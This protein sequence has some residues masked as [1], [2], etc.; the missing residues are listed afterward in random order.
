MHTTPR[1]LRRFARSMNFRNDFNVS[2]TKRGTILGSDL[3]FLLLNDNDAAPPLWNVANQG[4]SSVLSRTF[5]Q[6]FG[7]SARKEPP[8]SRGLPLLGS[9]LSLTI[10]GGAKKLHEYVDNKHQELGP[11]FRDQIGPIEAVFVNSPAEYRKVLADLAGNTPRHFLPESWMLYNE[12]R[13]QNRGLLFMEGEE[14]WHYRKILNKVML[15]PGPKIFFYGPCQE[16]AENLTKEW[17]RYC[18]IGCVIPNLEH[19]LYQWSIEVMLAAMIGSRWHVCEPRLRCDIEDLATILH[20]IF[21]YTS[22]LSMIPAKLAMKLRLPVWNKFVQAA[23][24]VL[25]KV[26]KLVPEMVRLSDNDGLLQTIL[27]NGIRGDEAVRIICDFVIAAGDTTSITMQW[28]LLLLSSHPELQDRLFNEI[29]DLPLEDLLQHQLLRYTWKETLR[30]HPVAPFLTRYLPVDSII[31][32]YFVPKGDLIIL[33][34]YSSGRDENNFLRPNEFWPERWF[35]TEK[36]SFTYRG[37][38]D[39]RASVPFA[40]GVRNCIGQRLAETQLSL[41]LAQL[42]KNFKI[43][44]ENRDRIKMILRMV[45]VPSESIKLKLIDREI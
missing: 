41:T 12:I 31:G 5:A 7:T 26:R 35:R 21:T 42:I 44:C 29:K 6:D 20:Q 3:R 33:S 19:R 43:Q 45:S 17:Q 4:L 27:N 9:V 24:E 37:V 23:D 8:E 25:D 18:R 28:A 40:V 13:V 36:D 16:A 15:K 11:V 39:A 22:R 14:W 32:G 30:L 10:S 34:L 1:T 2:F 38:K